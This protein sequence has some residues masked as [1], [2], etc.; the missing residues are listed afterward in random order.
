MIHVMTA[1]GRTPLGIVL[2]Q[3]HIQPV[4]AARG[5]NVK[6]IFSDLLDRGDACKRQEETEMVGKV[7]IP[8]GDS[9]AAAEVLSLEVRT[10]C[11]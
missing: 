7:L 3:L 9:F 1:S 4:E 6:S 2:E 8:A 10:V 5:S 11:R